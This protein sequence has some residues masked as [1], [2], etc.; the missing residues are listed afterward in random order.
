MIIQKKRIR[1][2]QKYLDTLSELMID[3]FYVR[4]P[5]S[6]DYY[7]KLKNIKYGDLIG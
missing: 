4:V 6:V 1:N 5:N 7:K 2:V 3:K